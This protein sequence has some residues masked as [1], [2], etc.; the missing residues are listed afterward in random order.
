[1]SSHRAVVALFNVLIHLFLQA[2]SFRY[3]V[4]KSSMQRFDMRIGLLLL[5]HVPCMFLILFQPIVFQA[6]MLSNERTIYD[7]CNY[8]EGH[9]TR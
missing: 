5:I 4:N 9:E 1:M 6:I 7:L 2:S 8:V 3:D